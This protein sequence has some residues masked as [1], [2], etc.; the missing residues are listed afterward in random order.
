FGGDSPV[1]IALRHVQQPVP[2]LPAGTPRSLQRIVARAL[3]KEP[4]ERYQTAA[5][6]ADELAYA[7]S[8]AHEAPDPVREPVS[9][10]R[11]APGGEGERSADRGER[12][13]AA[14]EPPPARGSTRVAPRF[15]ARHNV[16]PPAR[17][18]SMAA[19]ALAFGLLCAMVV[20]AIA[21]SA[22]P[23]VRVPELRGLT[24][25]AVAGKLRRAHLRVDFTT[26][27]A[28]AK[29]GTAVAQTPAVGT[30]VKQD[31]AIQ[32]ALSKGPRPV[33]VPSLA[34]QSAAE[35]TAR[36]HRI[37]LNA[38][39]VYVPAP[40][41]APGIV[42]GQSPAGGHHLRPH[43]TVTLSVAETP[44]WRTVTSFA[45]DGAGHS[46]AFKIRGSGWRVVYQMTYNG[47]CDFVLFCEGP[48][49]QVIGLGTSTTDTSFGM[50]DGG[51]ET[52]VFNT[53]PGE[54]QIAIKPGLDDARWSFTVQDWY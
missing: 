42:T 6:M 37:A 7:R 28:G 12:P 8:R 17:R 2:P 48:S 34:G 47:T 9:S 25:R 53:G 54:Y 3:A 13:T 31:S 21:L 50:S 49:A 29:V 20:S 52:R 18:R 33:A 27:F 35:A 24:R 51:S 45:G 11:D 36:L 19:L 43:S 10:L 38:K 32:V 46:V 40:G 39:L 16:N 14:G 30:R 1:E 26:Q 22:G 5:A 23:T 4:A 15:S 41:T 44:S